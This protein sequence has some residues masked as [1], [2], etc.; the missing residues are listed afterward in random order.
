MK[1]YLFYN[2]ILLMFILSY[3]QVYGNDRSTIANERIRAFVQVWGLVKYKSLNGAQGK[4]DADRV[5]LNLIDQVSNADENQF[6]Q[7]IAVL[8]KENPGKPEVNKSTINKEKLLTQNMDYNWIKDKIFIAS[9]QEQLLTL[10]RTRNPD[11]EHYYIPKIAYEG[12]IPHENPYPVYTF[13]Q[14]AMNLLA[15]A[16][17]WNAVVYLFP[18]RYLMDQKWEL[19]LKKLIPVF[20]TVK[21]K[22]TYEKSILLLE[23]AIDDTHASG[24]LNQLK[25]SA[26]IFDLKYYPPFAYKV[27]HDKLLVTEFLNDSLAQSSNLKAGDLI[28]EI[29]GMSTKKWLKQRSNLLPASNQSVKNKLLASTDALAFSAINDGTLR[30]S[31]KRG[32]KHL[33]LNLLLLDRMNP[34]VALIVNSYFKQKAIEDQLVKGY[35]DLTGDIALIRAGHFFDKNLPA[36]QELMA[37]SQNLNKKKAIIFDMRKYPQAPGLFYYYLPMALGKPAFKFAKYYGA[38]LNNPGVFLEK[39]GIEIFLSKDIKPVMPLYQGKIVILT[40]EYT[41]SMGEWF[42]MMLRQINANTTIIGSQ[43]AGTDGDVKHLNLPGGYEF[44]FT[45]NGIFY[46]NGKETQRV[47]IVPDLLYQ[48]NVADLLSAKDKQLEKALGYLE[49][50]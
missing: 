18:Y 14:E 9:V 6:N 25:C 36:D 28:I 46:P 37:F 42:T 27:Y 8:L 5:F 7:L 21:S 1:K 40:N 45:G 16:K 30:V 13:D 20:R 10:T 26:E 35:E 15:L 44:L 43:T 17:A 19:T 12:T 34:Q 49:N 47:G 23:S 2:F 38:D 24:F 32:N 29:N 33:D 3:N 22:A 50:K 48:P 11:G 41:Q 4:F 31:V 39:D